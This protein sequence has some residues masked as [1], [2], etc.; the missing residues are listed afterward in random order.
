MFFFPLPPGRASCL[1]LLRFLDALQAKR[2]QAITFIGRATGECL[3]FIY[4]QPTLCKAQEPSVRCDAFLLGS[5]VRT[6]LE[7]ILKPIP[8]DPFGAVTVNSLLGESGIRKPGI[9]GL[10]EHST[11]KS[12]AV[13]LQTR[14]SDSV[15]DCVDSLD[16]DIRDA[17]RHMR[18][19]AQSQAPIKPEARASAGKPSPAP[20]PKTPRRLPPKPLSAKAHPSTLEKL[21]KPSKKLDPPPHPRSSEDAPTP[22]LPQALPPTVAAF[23]QHLPSRELSDE[24]S[25]PIGSDRPGS[26]ASRGTSGA[27]M[28][29]CRVFIEPPSLQ[30]ELDVGFGSADGP[31]TKENEEKEVNEANEANEVNEGNEVHEERGDGGD[32][33]NMKGGEEKGEEKGGVEVDQ[34]EGTKNAVGEGGDAKKGEEKGEKKDEEN[35]G[36]GD[37][38][39]DEKNDEENDEEG[40]EKNDEKNDEESDKK[41]ES[42]PQF[43]HKN[44]ERDR[45][46]MAANLNEEGTPSNE[47]EPAGQATPTTAVAENCAETESVVQSGVPEIPRTKEEEKEEK[48]DVGNLE[49]KGSMESKEN[50]EDGGDMEDKEDKENKGGEEEEDESEGEE[51][52][53]EEGEGLES[54]IEGC[55]EHKVGPLDSP[56]PEHQSAKGPDNMEVAASVQQGN[57]ANATLTEAKAAKDIST[58]TEP[59]PLTIV[60]NAPVLVKKVLKNTVPA[61]LPGL[62]PPGEVVPAANCLP[63]RSPGMAAR[64]SL[65]PLARPFDVGTSPSK[66]T[67][68]SPEDAQPPT[69]AM[70]GGQKESLRGEP[71]SQA[72]STP[73]GRG[74]P[75]AQENAWT[76]ELRLL[77]M[78]RLGNPATKSMVKT[79]RNKYRQLGA[80]VLLTIIHRNNWD[81]E[82]AEQEILALL[83]KN[84]DA[85]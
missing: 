67:G 45:V 74:G 15:E 84:R 14:L 3:R 64:R 42:C 38:K 9:L 71:I 43:K 58:A 28:K 69:K 7:S 62:R 11:C 36:E 52:G 5:F 23:A 77:M 46:S 27:C 18:P 44:L 47:S 19:P 76:P 83:A 60:E 24:E 35:E 72:T 63:Q 68:G 2:T 51:E 61:G 34:K 85:K 31:R 40:G 1:T 29:G 39:N 50:T 75:A 12:V 70:P 20:A 33:G 4:K 48:A 56:A 30:D 66:P 13:A 53:E 8:R 80:R 32:T 22:D 41:K 37:E 16:Q 55:Q 78:A 54:P 79:L 26:F 57:G 49:N 10:E 65:N 81:P 59:A 21:G 73:T 82:S 25:H 6:I 17:L